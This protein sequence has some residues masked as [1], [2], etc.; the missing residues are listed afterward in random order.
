MKKLLRTASIV[1]MVWVM[2]VSISL[3]ESPNYNLAVAGAYNSVDSDDGLK[4]TLMGVGAKY[5]FAP[6]NPNKGPLNESEFLD[7]QTN[8]I[9][10]IGTIDID[11]DFGSTL[12]TKTL[13]GNFISVGFAEFAKTNI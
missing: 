11:V 6:V 8:V 5:F 3:A 4:I 1:S 7:R 13:S 9:G 2:T 10:L 12:G